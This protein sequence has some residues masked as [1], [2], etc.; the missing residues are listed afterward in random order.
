M[1][2][3]GTDWCGHCRRTQPL[4]TEAVARHP[5]VQHIRVID[6]PGKPLGRS[7]GVKLWPTVVLLREGR[8]VSRFVRPS[9]AE[10][11]ARAVEELQA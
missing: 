5:G 7:F 4:I 1:P 9:A 3:F 10:E 11:I 2:E 8:E 6:G